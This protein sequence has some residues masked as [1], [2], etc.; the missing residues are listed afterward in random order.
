[1]KTPKEK[2]DITEQLNT[3]L[4]QAFYD[5][6]EKFCDRS[7]T[8]LDYLIYRGFTMSPLEHGGC[9]LNWSVD[10]KISVKRDDFPKW[11]YKGIKLDNK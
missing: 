11:V 6:I 4:E 8:K 7:G 10:A 5:A 2:I 3:E 1:M 9:S